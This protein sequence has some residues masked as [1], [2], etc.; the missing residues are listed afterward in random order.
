MSLILVDMS[1]NDR[2]RQKGFLLG[3]V[4]GFKLTP[5][6]L[7]IYLVCTRRYR[8][9]VN[10]IAGFAATVLIGFAILPRDSMKYWSGLAWESSRAG[11][12]QDPRAHSVMSVLMR[13]MGTTDV[14]YIWL[15]IVV[16]IAVCGI[17]LAVITH[18]RL[19]DPAGLCVAALTAILV[20]PVSWN[21]HYVWVIPTIVV[22]LS[23]C[24]RERRVVSLVL[25]FI[26]ALDFYIHPYTWG[27]PVGERIDLNLDIRD[28]L[29]TSTYVIGAALLIAALTILA[30]D[31]KAVELRR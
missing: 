11:A 28:L 10:A 6:F 17:V 12:A 8:A 26:A 15:P 18:R 21:H 23:V 27:V 24:I 16:C 30:F 13:W 29:L 14:R 4:A 25:V 3:I 22:A 7:V 20:S 2:S 5:L 1:I 31:R 19:S 9:A